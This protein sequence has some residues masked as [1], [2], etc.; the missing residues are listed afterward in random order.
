MQR[1][2]VRMVAPDP[3][4]SDAA[5]ETAFPEQLNKTLFDLETVLIQRVLKEAGRLY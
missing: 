1:N 5:L 2:A 3:K 4:D